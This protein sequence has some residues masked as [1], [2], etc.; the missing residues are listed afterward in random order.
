MLSSPLLCAQIAFSVDS[1]APFVTVAWVEKPASRTSITSWAWA[2][3][4]DVCGMI[5]ECV[6]VG[7]CHLDYDHFSTTLWDAILRCFK[8]LNPHSSSVCC[9]RL[10]LNDPSTQ[11][12]LLVVRSYIWHECSNSGRSPWLL[13]TI[14]DLTF[15]MEAPSVRVNELAKGSLSCNALNCDI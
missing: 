8:R 13:L 10:D 14:L 3:L 6:S 15:L 11:S 2:K 9:Q 1:Y 12:Y 4:S 7:N 5:I